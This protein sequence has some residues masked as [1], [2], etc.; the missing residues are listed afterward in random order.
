ME[1]ADPI[2]LPHHLR[3]FD[4]LQMNGHLALSKAGIQLADRVTTVSPTYARE[5]LEEPAGQGL[6]AALRWRGDAFSGILNGLDA[7][8]WPPSK[9]PVLRDGTH[10]A[11]I[12]RAAHQKGLDL[13]IEAVDELVALGGRLSVISSGDPALEAGLRA[14]AERYP[15]RVNVFIGFHEPMAQELYAKADFVLVPSRFE[16]CGLTQ[17]I[18]M[19][20]GAIPIVRRTGGLADT[21][22]DGVTGLVFDHPTPLAL[23]AAIRRARL[24]PSA[25][26]IAMRD[27][28]VAQDWSWRPSA[29]AYI[30]L[31]KSILEERR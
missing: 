12:S 16:P 15:T 6:A 13:V 4:G 5:V 29:Q 10:F 3:G 14:C 1:W 17:M 2:G 8:L 11:V 20:Y 22:E 27:R 25:E 7:D 24:M 19:R 31:Y 30:N 21:V 23:R 18:A 26:R 9:K 28:C